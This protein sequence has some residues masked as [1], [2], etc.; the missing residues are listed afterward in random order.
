MSDKLSPM[1]E[2]LLGQASDILQSVT[3]T[4]SKA[5]NFA[6]EQIPDIAL[7]YVAYG[8][9]IETTLVLLGVLIMAAALTAG[10]QLVVKNALKFSETEANWFISVLFVLPTFATGALVFGGNLSQF[11]MVWVAPKVW[12]IKELVN[13]VK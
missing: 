1:Q 9:A 6:A 5:T 8:R 2:Q 10:Y 4:V 12:L 13:L 3:D 7:Q 11:F